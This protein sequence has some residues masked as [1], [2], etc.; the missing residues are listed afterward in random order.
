MTGTQGERAKC[1]ERHGD[2]GYLSAGLKGGG[3]ECN[4]L[5]T[6][7]QLSSGEMARLGTV[8]SAVMSSGTPG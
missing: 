8:F 6:L 2:L 3:V 4:D 7:E 5:Y 1:L